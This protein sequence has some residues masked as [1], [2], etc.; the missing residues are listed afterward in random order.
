MSSGCSRSG[1]GACAGIWLINCTLRRL[2]ILRVV[3]HGR[4]F[5]RFGLPLALGWLLGDRL[6]AAGIDWEAF[7]VTFAVILL[8]HPVVRFLS[9]KG[10]RS[11]VA[12]SFCSFSQS[13]GRTRRI[14]AAFSPGCADGFQNLR[15]R[16]RGRSPGR[17]LWGIPG[18]GFRHCPFAGSA[19]HQPKF[20]DRTERRKCGNFPA[21]RKQERLDWL[22]A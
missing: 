13:R 2:D 1:G 10:L 12:K 7:A 15:W 6:Q 20:R 3:Q 19:S 8:L 16:S 17:S 4:S 5:A 22:L 21:G 9:A 18:S 11:P 14:R